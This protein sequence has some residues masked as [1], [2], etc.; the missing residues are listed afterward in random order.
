MAT[1]TAATKINT[2]EAKKFATNE[3]QYT[4]IRK[5]GEG[6][7]GTVFLARDKERRQVAIKLIKASASIIE[8]LFKKRPSQLREAYQE[9]RKLFRLQ[10]KNIVEIIQ[11]FEFTM[12]F[13][14]QGFAIVTEYYSKGSLEQCLK[15]FKQQPPNV[16]KRLNWYEQLADGLAFIHIKN[17]AHRDLKPANI[18]VDSNDNLKIGDVGLAKTI[19][20][21]QSESGEHN[22]MTFERYMSSK[23]GTPLYM[24]PEVWRGEY[25]ITCDVF[26]IGLVYVM[27]A[28][29]PDPLRPCILH[30]TFGLGWWLKDNI[31]SRSKRA[32]ELLY[33]PLRIARNDEKVLFDEMLRY[34]TNSR[35]TMPQVKMEIEK[36]KTT[37][38]AEKSPKKEQSPEKERAP[39]KEQAPEK[40]NYLDLITTCFF[41]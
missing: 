6:A 29:C 21:I 12:S 5:I 13:F 33:P 26:S 19:W 25:R 14:T 20:D 31:P 4:I 9:A 35:L 15:S 40:T 3:G 41:G 27:I 18:L 22:D 11:K 36:I 1:S 17:I 24:A 2:D 39:E 10:H 32:T 30:S 34:D 38:G 23:V 28:E 16:M 7:F 37:C 8:I